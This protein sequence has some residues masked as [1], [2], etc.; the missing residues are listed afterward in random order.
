MRGNAATVAGGG[1]YGGGSG[2]AT[3]YNDA[4][5]ASGGGGGGSNYLSPTATSNG[6]TGIAASTSVTARVT[7]SYTLPSSAPIR[8]V[9]SQLCI[10]TNL[11][12]NPALAACSGVTPFHTIGTAGA[13]TFAIGDTTNRCLGTGYTAQGSPVGL[14]PCF[15]GAT[16]QQWSVASPRKAAS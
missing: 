10:G 4:A 11:M 16:D 8:Q 6:T 14:A 2:G 7:I 5:H 15:P 13:T 12:Q 3:M 1:W 9:G